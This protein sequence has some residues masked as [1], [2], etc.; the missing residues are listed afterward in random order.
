[1][2]CK[3]LCWLCDRACVGCWPP[4]K[5]SARR[6]TNPSGGSA[7]PAE[8]LPGACRRPGAMALRSRQD[9]LT[10]T[11]A[12][13]AQ[14]RVQWICTVSCFWTLLCRLVADEC[15]VQG[16]TFLVAEAGSVTAPRTRVSL[17]PSCTSDYTAILTLPCWRPSGQHRSGHERR[18]CGASAEGSLPI[19]G[20]RQLAQPEVRRRLRRPAPEAVSKAGLPVPGPNLHWDWRRQS[21]AGPGP[22]LSAVLQACRGL[23][24]SRV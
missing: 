11:S 23:H 12:L 24:C 9:E 2:P 10:H 1:M 18:T 4:S 6:H 19:Q 17:W 3:R 15:A 8:G 22:A 20:F 7:T 13:Q 16:Q 14:G 5:V 21:S